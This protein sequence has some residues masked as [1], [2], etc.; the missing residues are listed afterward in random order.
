MRISEWR[1]NVKLKMGW[2]PARCTVVDLTAGV[3]DHLLAFPVAWGR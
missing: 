1:F 2:S 3:V